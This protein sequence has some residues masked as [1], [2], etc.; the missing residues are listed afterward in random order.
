[1]K[2]GARGEGRG[3]RNTK[4]SFRLA[5]LVSL[6]FSIPPR[7]SAAE[8]DP[9]AQEL[10]P[11]KPFTLQTSDGKL[12]EP[13]ELRG[14]VWVAHF[15]Y[16][17][18]TGGCTK[19]VP[20]MKA[21]QEAFDGCER[22]V[23]LVSISLNNDSPDT[24]GRYA[25]DMGADPKQWL[26]LT[27]PTSKVHDIVQ[28]VFYQTAQASGSKEPGREIDHSFNL[29]IVDGQ[30][31]MR[32]YVD[33]SSLSNVPR[34]E[35]R[36]RELVRAKFVLPALN[37]V[38]NALCAMLL[39][40]GYVAIR[41]KRETLHKACMLSALIVSAVFL[42]SYLY[43]HFEVLDGQP[44]RFQ[45]Q[46]TVRAVYFAILLTHTALAA[47]VAPL[48]LYVAYQGLRDHRPRH[49]K[50]ARCTLPI[51]LYVSVTGVVVYVM[52]YHLYPPI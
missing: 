11:V 36:V 29:V 23:A 50:V 28:R 4:P 3:A 10:G 12:F 1:M 26:F 5:L 9:L 37:A 2:R 44:T 49:V 34:L 21:L 31:E 41:A 33:G 32:G 24:L 47:L 27:G 17:T 15:F 52:L 6:F 30:G 39:I 25:R 42:T 48:A 7:A 13:S 38:L 51:W 45:G 19:T 14:K 46:G 40:V 35:E 16:T 20:V 18:C 43:F 22:D 8:Y